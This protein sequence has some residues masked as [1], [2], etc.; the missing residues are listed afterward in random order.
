MTKWL[1]ATQARRIRWRAQLL[2]GSQLAPTEVVSRAVALQG[3][4][5]RAVLRAIAIRSRPGTS[6]ADVAAAFDRGE[7]VRSW[8]MRGTLFATTPA[9]LAALLHFTGAR[10]LAAAARRRAALGLTDAV[11]AT[12]RETLVAALTDRP[13]TRAEAM[14]L[15]GAA[16]I[17][18]SSGRG[19]HLLMSLFVEGLACWGPLTPDGREQLLTAIDLPAPPDP[20][21]AL[22]ELVRGY[23]LARGPVTLDDLA[24]WTKLPKTRLRRATSASPDLGEALVDETPVLLV[25]EPEDPEPSGVT[26]APAFDEWI[27]GY[28]DRSWT[29]S[30]KMRAALTPGDNGVFRPCV[31]VDGVTVGV[32]R[33]PLRAGAPQPPELELVEP[34]GV[35]VRRQ[36]ERALAAWPHG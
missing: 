18:T 7:Q 15:W 32:W 6:V 1:T 28:A 5:L 35:R 13:L 34:V 16:G 33:T 25:G 26:L 31:L 14:A 23:A 19:Y 21:A 20:D 24:W 36:I 29:A 2:G 9:H 8:P 10:T 11:I 27:L 4:D 3:Q 22:A 12:A 30:P 17:D